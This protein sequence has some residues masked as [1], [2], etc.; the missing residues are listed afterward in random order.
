[1]N[2]KFEIDPVLWAKLTRNLVNTP[3]DNCPDCHHKLGT[4]E[5]HC[6]NC[7]YYNDS[8]ADDYLEGNDNE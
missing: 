7:Y 8:H 4:N 1:M 3:D 2:K 5:N 6:E